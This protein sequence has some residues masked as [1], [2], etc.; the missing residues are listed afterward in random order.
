MSMSDSN[1][2]SRR[3]IRCFGTDTGFSA[4]CVT[5]PPLEIAGSSSGHLLLKERDRLPQLLKFLPR[6]T[7][8]PV[9]H[10]SRKC[11]ASSVCGRL[12]RLFFSGTESHFHVF[13][14]SLCVGC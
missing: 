10:P 7:P 5:R 6:G 1:L 8:Q 3:S 14:L 2:F 12:E 11:E 13:G 4:D 9:S